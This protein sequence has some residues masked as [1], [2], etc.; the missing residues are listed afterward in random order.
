ML[1][2]GYFEALD[3]PLGPISAPLGPIWSQNASQQIDPKITI[4]NVKLSLI[5]G[6]WF[7]MVPRWL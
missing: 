6:V 4:K 3:G 7:K 5:L 2:F 1:V